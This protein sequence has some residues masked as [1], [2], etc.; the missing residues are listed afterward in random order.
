[1]AGTAQR[2]SPAAA[3]KRSV[4]P[5]CAAELIPAR[6]MT[7]PFRKH[8]RACR[9]ACRD[10]MAIVRV[11]EQQRLH[12]A[13]VEIPGPVVVRR[14]QALKEARES[15][16]MSAELELIRE[17]RPHRMLL[18]VPELFEVARPYF[19]ERATLAANVRFAR[20]ESRPVV[21]RYGGELVAHHSADPARWSC[22]PFVVYEGY[23]LP[24]GW[25]LPIAGFEG[26]FVVLK[27]HVVMGTGEPRPL[28]SGISGLL[29]PL[30]VLAPADG[31]W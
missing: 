28:P 11:R 18:R 27:P 25:A 10:C 30:D 2:I 15:G 29:A 13:D 19:R 3:A 26:T 31:V 17:S 9:F 16:R 8:P 21:E 23:G 14:L 20:G 7:A 6:A 24:C 22:T 4:C 1:M 12:V 5:V